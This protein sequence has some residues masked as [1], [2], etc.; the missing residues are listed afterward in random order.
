MTDTLPLSE[1]TIANAVVPLVC[2]C[3][4][5]G[6]PDGAGPGHDLGYPNCSTARAVALAVL[7]L[8]G[9]PDPFS[10]RLHFTGY[11]PDPQSVSEQLGD[12]WGVLRALSGLCSDLVDASPAQPA[13]PALRALDRAVHAAARDA[14]DAWVEA[15]EAEA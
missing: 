10:A 15:Q 2:R 7:E 3:S 6:Q 13:A 8:A 4:P 14:H 1:R 11:V 5:P 9:V 12:V